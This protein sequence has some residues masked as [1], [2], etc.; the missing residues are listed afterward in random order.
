[1]SQ[2]SPSLA[3]AGGP[4]PP[5][6]DVLVAWPRT[7]QWAMAVLLGLATLLIAL[8]SLGASRWGARPTRLE[9]EAGRVDLNRADRAQLLQLPDVGESLAE[10]I[11]EYRRTNG[12]FRSVEDLKKVH[13]IGEA[14]LR[15]LRPW[16]CVESEEDETSDAEG[17]PARPVAM[18]GKSRASESAST[19]RSKKSETLAEPVDINRA[20]AEQLQQ[21]PG[22]GPELARRI[23][24]RRKIAP[25][26]SVE[27]LRRVRG[28]G[29]KT[30][31]KLRPYVTVGT[32]PE[33]AA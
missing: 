23:I 1:M 32:T 6:P 13:G 17:P 12:P 33:R 3:S 15:N 21:L 19:S 30:L 16:V 10:R 25:F 8:S 18:K 22:I 27:E 31:E 9:R 26:R 5:Q 20:N 2:T 28:I 11:E 29:A 4:A 14:R 24:D 7:A